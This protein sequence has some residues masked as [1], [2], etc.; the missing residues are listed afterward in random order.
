MDILLPSR[1]S[2]ENGIYDP[3][4][5]HIR[6]EFPLALARW[7]E[8][9]KSLSDKERGLLNITETPLALT[10]SVGIYDGTMYVNSFCAGLDSQELPSFRLNSD[11]EAYHSYLVDIKTHLAA[12]R[13][14]AGGRSDNVVHSLLERM[15][16]ST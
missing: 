9:A 13:K 6:D 10:Q 15:E 16:G 11:L 5:T 2:V 3:H 4:K 1:E 7:R 12:G 14:M 8:F